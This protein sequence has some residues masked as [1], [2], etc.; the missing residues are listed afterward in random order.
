MPAISVALI[1]PASKAFL[2]I[3]ST[4]S[5]RGEMP[6]MIFFY[7]LAV[8]PIV[9]SLVSDQKE[10][11]SRFWTSPPKRRTVDPCAAHRIKGAGWC[12]S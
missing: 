4:L 2:I 5:S 12:K 9:N 10:I 3:V 11:P 1:N 6:L 7:L 8:V